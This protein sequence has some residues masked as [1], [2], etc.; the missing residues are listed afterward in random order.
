MVKIKEWI[1]IATRIIVKYHS[2]RVVQ[3]TSVR[4]RSIR[5]ILHVGGLTGLV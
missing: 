5:S 1:D 4:D 3:F 2:S